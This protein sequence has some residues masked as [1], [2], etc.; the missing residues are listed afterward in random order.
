V[1]GEV[2]SYLSCDWCTT[3]LHNTCTKQDTC[4][5]T[6]V[7]GPTHMACCAKTHAQ[8]KIHGYDPCGGS[9]SCVLCCACVVQ[10]C[11]TKIFS[12]KRM[13]AKGRWP[14]IRKTTLWQGV[15]FFASCSK[16]SY[17]NPSFIKRRKRKILNFHV[18]L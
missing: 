3:R 13:N 7:I 11:C 8:H 2:E 9:H 6:H 14:A 1:S 15:F 4:G 18:S 16:C 17:N 12:H 5:E 10:P